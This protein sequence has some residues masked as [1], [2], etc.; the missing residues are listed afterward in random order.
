MVAPVAIER[1]HGSLTE[2]DV[3]FAPATREA[4]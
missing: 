3:L 2:G 4:A 1:D